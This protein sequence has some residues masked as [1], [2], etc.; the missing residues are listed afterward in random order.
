MG[1][2][3]PNLAVAD[4]SL[5]EAFALYETAGQQRTPELSCI[6]ILAVEHGRIA[7]HFG[8]PSDAGE[9]R[10]FAA[11]VPEWPVFPET[12]DALRYLQ[13]C[14]TL[15]IISNVDRDSFRGTSAKLGITFDIVITAD[16]AGSYKPSH[17]NFQTAVEKPA[18]RGIVADRILHVGQSYLHDIVPASSFGL[19]TMWI[20]RRQRREGWGATPPPTRMDIKPSFVATDLAELAARHRRLA[21][22]VGLSPS[23]C[24]TR[25]KRLQSEGLIKGCGARVDLDRMIVPVHVFAE[26]T[27]KDQGREDFVRFVAR[28]VRHYQELV[29][30][31]VDRDIGIARCSSY[32]VIKRDHERLDYRLEELLAVASARKVV[33]PAAKR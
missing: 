17:R 16:E 23:P 8:Q 12:L 2:Q 13:R 19:P 27:L 9:A 25:V 24:L 29:E 22:S 26:F 28:D 21:E 4:Q 18:M 6:E 1:A 11:S 5:L 33:Q 31:L 32:V 7:E 14:V 20:D 15:T 10:A 30:G 3:R